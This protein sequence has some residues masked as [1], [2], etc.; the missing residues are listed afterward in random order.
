MTK[1]ELIK[2]VANETGL[3]ITSVSRMMDQTL[4]I[5]SDELN[6]KQVVTIK[7]FGTFSIKERKSRNGINPATKEKIVIPAK[8]V[9]CFKPASKIRY[10]STKL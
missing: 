2:A 9:V 4:A 8:E 5:I 1:V 3:T 7:D 6:K 10:Y